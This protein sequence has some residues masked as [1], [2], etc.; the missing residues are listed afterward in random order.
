M[1][2]PVTRLYPPPNETFP[3]QGLYLGQGLH[4]QGTPE[5]PFVYS[6][7]IATLDGRIAIP[8]AG[9]A[10]HEVP[11]AATNPRDWRLYQELA[12]QADLLITSGRFLRQ[13]A[14]GEAQDHLPVSRSGEFSDI[15]E[16]R[17]RQGLREQP[18]IAILSRSLDI[19]VGS[20]EKYRP[21]RLIILTGRDAAEERIRH[22]TE[23]GAEVI[24]AGAG[25]HADGGELINALAE[26]GYRSIYAVAGP[27]VFR[28]LVAAGVLN[29]LYLTITHQLLAGDVFDT[30]IQGAGLDPVYGMRL[31]S[32]YHDPHA[33]PGASQWFCVFE[34]RPQGSHQKPAYPA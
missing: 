5:Q 27:G 15:L 32:L 7:F 28:T 23:A 25:Q 29:R 6:N 3:L 17:A 14:A 30:I 26:Q 22:L 1:N 33:P 12:G 34:S 20:L 13:Q 8:A 31:L 10:S 11:G 4:R 9:R 18:D 21:R 24:R 19:P 16:W 2:S